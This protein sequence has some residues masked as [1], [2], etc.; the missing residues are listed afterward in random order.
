MPEYGRNVQKMVDIAVNLPTRE[1]RTRSA[2]TIINIMANMNPQ[3]RDTNDFRNKLWD[4]LFIISDYKL[5]VD[6]PFPMPNRVELNKHPQPLPYPHN[7][8]KLKHYGLYVE[9][10]I[11]AAKH[12]DCDAKQRVLVR[13]IANYMKKTLHSLNKDFATDERLFSDINKLSAG[14]I[15]VAEGTQPARNQRDF[16]QQRNNGKQFF[17]KKNK[18]QN[19]GQNKNKQAHNKQNNRRNNNR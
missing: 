6:S 14:E 4:H 12:V 7:R 3:L 19:K 5:D 1:E 8:I 16:Y 17:N 18:N 11:E 15:H 13:D 9:K 2:H 10:F